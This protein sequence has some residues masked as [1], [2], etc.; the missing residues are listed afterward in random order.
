ME[1]PD[2][3]LEALR[4]A[5]ATLAVA[6]SFTGGRLMDAFT[7]VSGASQVF[8]GG[9]VAYS[10]ASK[11]SLLRVPLGRLLEHGA[12]SESTVVDMA[13]GARRILGATFAVATSGIAGPTGATVAKPL[14]LSFTAAAG[15]TTVQATRRVHP[16]SRDD[17]K[18]A[19]FAQ[20]LE[21]LAQVLRREGIL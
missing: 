20:A 4:R 6:E 9:L 17:V 10:D 8:V 2:E 16:G 5:G 3:L 15:P 13:R 18:A 1:R 14:G 19:A 7:N 11:R 12:V 21:V